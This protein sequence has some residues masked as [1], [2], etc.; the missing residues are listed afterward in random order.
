MKRIFIICFII[1]GYIPC[2]LAQQSDKG[3]EQGMDAGKLD[4]LQDSIAIYEAL[5]GWWKG[6]RQTVDARMEWYN[7]TKFGCFVHWGVYSDAGGEWNGHPVSGYSE[8][9]M[10][11][12][13]IPLE[14]YKQRLVYPFN[15][16][17]FDADEW[18]RLAKEAGMRYFIVT[19][20]HHDGFAMYHSDAYP[21]DMRLT[22][23]DRDPMKELSDAAK[24]YGIK[25]GFYYS[26]A[27]DWEHP[28]APG[29]DWMYNNP[30][31]DKLLGGTN[32]WLTR[33]DFL[34]HADKYV[35]EKSIP[36]I[37]EL[38][39]KYNPDIL[40]FDTPHKLPLYQNVR[41]MKAIR[42][43]APDIVVNGRLARFPGGNLGDYANTGDRSAYFFPSKGYWESIP[44]TNESYGYSKYDHSHKSTAHFIRLLASAA[45]K[46]GNILMNVG[47]MG[48]GKWDNTD[49]EIFR[50]VGKWLNSYGES[51]YG[52]KQTDLPIQPWGVTTRKADSLYLH[53]FHWPEDGKIIVGGLTSEMVSATILS[54]PQQSVKPTRINAWDVEIRLPKTA[55]DTVNTVIAL[56]LKNQKPANPVRLLDPVAENILAAFDADLMGKGLGYGDGKPHRNYVRG[57]TQN[58]QGLLWP[59]RLS[60][61]AA[62]EVY[63]QYNT[64]TA[65]NDGIVLL[66]VNSQSN[67]SSKAFEIPY[68]S[69]T[70]NQG[71]NTLPVGKITLPAGET[72]IAL[73]GKEYT[74]TGF[75]R[76]ISVV[77][78]PIN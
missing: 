44:T 4:L 40:W 74:G 23:F 15:P 8:H 65:W 19:A 26:H 50:G 61:P 9:L 71:T 59:V 53:I 5:N 43:A 45:S 28:D 76:P 37:L 77:L 27:F 13:C 38:I 35:T 64:D 41:I 51:I 22:K 30:G 2:L 25:F 14:E 63:L 60:T 36:Q 17:E 29:N 12:E 67:E 20:K 10:R 3:D 54:H 21:Y 24:K 11:K 47:P 70:E 78:K 52:S 34:P 56:K 42:E 46:G 55:P 31:G 73:K 18:M 7:D 62:Y 57:W 16:T 49:V 75:M 39:K 72:Q 1:L 58:D 33:K 32:W 68:V 69:Y 6:A 66:E 48:N